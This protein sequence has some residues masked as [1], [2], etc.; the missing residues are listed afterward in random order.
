[1]GRKN[2]LHKYGIKVNRL[3][4]LSLKEGLVVTFTWR[5][6]VS[7]CKE[8]TV[9]PGHISKNVTCKMPQWILS[10]SGTGICSAP[11]EKDQVAKK[12]SSA[13]KRWA[14]KN[15]WGWLKEPGLCSLAKGWDRNVINFIPVTGNGAGRKRMIHLSCAWWTEHKSMFSHCSKKDPS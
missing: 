6:I 11:Q 9:V 14:K 5:R 1:M 13:K 7:C 10:L 15:Q 2:C 4:T 3:D 12:K 8:G